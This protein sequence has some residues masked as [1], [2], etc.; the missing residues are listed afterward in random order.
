MSEDVTPL[1]AFQKNPETTATETAEQ[2]S[3]PVEPLFYESANFRLRVTPTP[4]GKVL[5]EI[6]CSPTYAD[7][8]FKEAIATVRQHVVIPGFR[9][10]K[11]PHEHV[12]KCYESAIQ[13]EWKRLLRT[14]GLEFATSQ[15]DYVPLVEIELL[16]VE[17]EIGK[18]GSPP[19]MRCLCEAMPPIPVVDL[20]LLRSKLKPAPVLPVTQEDK[21]SAL[22]R[23]RLFYATWQEVDRPA[24]EGD[25]V[26]VGALDAD[27]QQMLESMQWNVIHLE[28]RDLKINWVGSLVGSKIGDEKECFVKDETDPSHDD[29]LYIDGAN[30]VPVKIVKIEEGTLHPLDDALAQKAGCQDVA[31]LLER[32]GAN[33]EQHAFFNT[34]QQ[35]A[36]NI[37]EALLE[38]YPITIPYALIR[39]QVEL[40]RPILEAAPLTKTQFEAVSGLEP[41]RARDFLHMTHL[42]HRWMRD[43]NIGISRKDLEEEFSHHQ[44]QTNPLDHY[45]HNQMSG[46][47]MHQ[48]LLL[49]ATARKGIYQ[50]LIELYP[51]MK[52]KSF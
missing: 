25:R 2:A 43:K 17:V 13:Q 34:A 41:H 46:P 6:E 45:L 36:A 15:S 4:P 8:L 5:F 37:K 16:K 48:Q 18:A 10:G 27:K 11:A 30:A 26:Y 32:I 39:S 42:F 20:E 51:E 38:T 47:V 29:A 52:N 50:M 35:R 24:R 19:F 33:L 14:K 49:L 31:Q 44:T 1:S 9:K 12:L 3:T 28:P 22:H 21:D 7:T 23:L 40:R